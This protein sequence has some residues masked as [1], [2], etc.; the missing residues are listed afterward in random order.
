MAPEQLHAID[1]GRL[2][3]DVLAAHVDDAFHA[4]AGGDGR[5]RDAVLAGAGFGDDRGLPMRLA[6]MA[7]PMQLFTLWRRY[8]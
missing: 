2:A 1:V 3:L 4:V 7:W 6:S 5:R 8:G